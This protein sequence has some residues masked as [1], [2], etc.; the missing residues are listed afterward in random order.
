MFAERLV[1]RLPARPGALRLIAGSVA[2]A[3]AR[4]SG[5]VWGAGAFGIRLDPALPSAFAGVAAALFASRQRG[6]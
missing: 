4:S 2:A 6:G 5:M 3:L 1:R